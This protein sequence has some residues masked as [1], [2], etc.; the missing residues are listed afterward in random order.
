LQALIV[1]DYGRLLMLKVA[2]FGVMLLMAA[3]RRFWLTPRLALRREASRSSS[4]S[5]AGA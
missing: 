1:T 5:P 3:D 2:L 4:A